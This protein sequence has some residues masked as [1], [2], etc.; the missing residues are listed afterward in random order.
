ML[1][2]FQNL[3]HSA[4][5]ALQESRIH[6]D[7]VDLAGNGLTRADVDRA[8]SWGERTVSLTSN[9]FRERVPIVS[10]RQT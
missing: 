9:S 10:D 8:G 1:T 6:A 7:G 3:R 2:L 5:P 4:R